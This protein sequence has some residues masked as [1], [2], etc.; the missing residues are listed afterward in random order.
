MEVESGTQGI[1][2]Q[3]A[4]G[5][6]LGKYK[7]DRDVVGCQFRWEYGSLV[8]CLIDLYRLSILPY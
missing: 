6:G 1:C 7:H 2:G 8:G 3:V 5:V 4:W